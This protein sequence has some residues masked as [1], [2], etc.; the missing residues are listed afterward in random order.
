[1]RSTSVV[2]LILVAGVARAEAPR[3]G[4]ALDSKTYPQTTP[5]ETLTSVLKAVENKRLDYLTAQLADPMFIDDRVKR[6]YAG[7]FQEQVEDTATRF[8]PSTAKLLGRFLKEG[9][10]MMANETANVRLKDVK[11]RMVFFRKVGARW[12]LEHRTKS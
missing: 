5:Q 8:D 12:Y 2:L 7:N 10:W 9:E 4:V 1:M 3:Y 11:D 6:L